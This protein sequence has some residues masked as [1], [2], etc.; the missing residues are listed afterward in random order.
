MSLDPSYAAFLAGKAPR[1]L[2]TGIE[3][4]AL[5]A[6]LFDFQAHC[7]DFLLRQ[8]RG[9]LFLGTGL[10][11]TACQLEWSR[12][13]AEATNGRALILTPLAVA[14]QTEREA[15]RFGYEARVIREQAD[16]GPGINICN[17][18]RLDRLDPDAF[19]AVSLDEGSIL[20]A[21]T[22]ATTRR[23]IQTFSSHRFR[24]SAT[25]TPAPNDHMELGQQADFLG[26]MAANEMLSRY[27]INDT[28]K[29]SQEWRLKRHAEAQFW[30]WMASWS[31]MA[32]GPED[33]GFDGS[34][35]AL[36]DMRIVKHRAAG[37]TRAPAGALFIA[38]MSATNMHDVKRQTAGARADAVAALVSADPTQP[39]VVWCD[40]DYEA[41]ALRARIPEAA[42]VRGSHPIDRKE[43]TLAA[44]AAGEVRVLI[45]KPSVA[46]FGCNWQHCARMAFVGRSFSYEA[47][48]QAVRR[49]WRFGQTR[50]VEVH[51]IVAE[52][53]DQ[54]GRVI[55]RKAADHA[56]MKAAMAEAMRR[57][58]ASAA[59]VRVPYVPRHVAVLP[60]WIRSAA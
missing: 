9:G 14:R 31:R 11:K 59:N 53:E 37:D 22:G 33:L 8:G 30:D 6:H 29:A 47:W 17:Y 32:D 13:A 10:G 50:A 46:G 57:S 15:H 34:A 25:A 39:W 27:F 44:F 20:K 60:N 36:P 3:P 43:D 48:Y 55:D 12:Q 38:E 19:G 23:L 16:A 1:A 35:F 54:I 26:V 21:F 41:D 56:R 5:P 52:G 4:R 51:V 24:L 18:D 58:N 2:A 45:T 49:C 40:T 42:E 7:V 28:S